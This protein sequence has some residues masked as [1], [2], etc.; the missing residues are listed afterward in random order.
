MFNLAFNSRATSVHLWH[1]HGAYLDHER[2]FCPRH[3]RIWVLAAAILAASM[4]FMDRINIS[5]ATPML[6]R[7][8][9]ATLVEGQWV[10]NSYLLILSSLIL[11]SAAIGERYGLRRTLG[12]GVLLFGFGA[13]ACAAAPEPMT[14]IG[15]RGIQGLGAA[16]MV[17]ASLAIVAKAYPKDERGK[18]IGI[19]AAASS[20]LIVVGPVM[21]GVIVATLGESG[22]RVLFALNVPIAGLVLAI[23]FRR[24]PRDPAGEAQAVDWTGALL[25]TASLFFVAIGL[26]GAMP[27]ADASGAL[28]LGIGG[29]TLVW[30]VTWEAR[31]KNPLVPLSL[32]A[33]KSFSGANAVTFLNDFAISANLFFLPMAAIAG[34]GE[35]AAS[36]SI[37]FLPLPIAI[38]VLSE[39]SGWL[40]DRY[41]PA[42]LV[43]AGSVLV[44]LACAGL[45]LTATE[46]NLLGRA[47]PLMALMAVGQGLLVS[48][49]STAV[50][51][52]ENDRE[53]IV[54]SSVNNA[55]SRSAWLISVAAMGS[56]ASFVFAM[57]VVGT[58][59]EVSGLSFGQIP[60]A[61]LAPELNAITITANS[62]AYAAIAWITAALVAVSA[63]ISAATLEWKTPARV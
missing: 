56:I 41:G 19:W 13:A 40:A 38:V 29:A 35:S 33:N 3:A 27:I 16:L 20:L 22:W 47:L 45:A 39:P 60:D 24:T 25:I 53:A 28:L 49:L 30:F 57:H 32:F 36:V 50:M 7:D 26:T 54:G 18:A 14:L 8:L 11:I 37:L 63:L 9:D 46:D 12:A 34:W 42:P 58:P 2:T 6:R 59:V 51:T 43:T 48:P 10:S 55:I 15:F 31:H 62:I 44:A 61:N 1:H 4:G 52:S 17:P 5:L 23:L 21:A